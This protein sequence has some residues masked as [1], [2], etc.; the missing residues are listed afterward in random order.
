MSEIDHHMTHTIHIHYSRLHH[1]TIDFQHRFAVNGL[2][3]ALCEKSGQSDPCY[4]KAVALL[5]L[6]FKPLQLLP[7]RPIRPPGSTAMPPAGLFYPR[8]FFFL[9][10]APVIQ[11]RVHGS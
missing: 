11:Q 3:I 10:V 9:T 4:F 2:L 6:S 7:L 5:L 8:F 1:R